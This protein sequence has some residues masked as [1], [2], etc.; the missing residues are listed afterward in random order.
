VEGQLFDATR[1]GDAGVLAA[2]LDDHPEKLHGGDAMGW[3]DR[4]GR[5]D[6]VHLLKAHASKP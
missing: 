2:L 6:V 3:A 1:N 5:Q 4:F